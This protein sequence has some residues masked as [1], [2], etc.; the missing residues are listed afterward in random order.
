MKSNTKAN[1]M[2]SRDATLGRKASLGEGV[3][4]QEVKFVKHE[5]LAF[6]GKNVMVE[7]LSKLNRACLG[8]NWRLLSDCRLIEVSMDSE[9]I[10]IPLE[11]VSTIKV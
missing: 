9:K 2:P 7:N 3:E 10:Y 11:R 6:Q 4:V 8:M 1:G 5:R